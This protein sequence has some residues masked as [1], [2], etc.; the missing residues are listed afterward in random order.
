MA[1]TSKTDYEATEICG[2]VCILAGPTAGRWHN[3]PAVTHFPP[4]K[5]GSSGK[6]RYDVSQQDRARA[7]AG[8][9]KG[10][11]TPEFL[12]KNFFFVLIYLLVLFSGKLAEFYHAV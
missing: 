10:V 2:G 6:R 5:L 11:V 3:V 12:K 9:L 7:R 4:N 8:E 1:I